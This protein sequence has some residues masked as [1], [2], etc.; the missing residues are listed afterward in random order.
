MSIKVWS[1]LRLVLTVLISLLLVLNILVR[2]LNKI[3]YVTSLI[4]GVL[5]IF[6]AADIITAPEAEKSRR[7]HK[8]DPLFLAKF[9]LF[10]MGFFGFCLGISG[11]V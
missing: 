1:R 6:M 8:S 7:Y 10:I 2:E 4:A 3:W 11:I 5:A 9:T